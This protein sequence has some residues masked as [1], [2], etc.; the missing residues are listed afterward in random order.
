MVDYQ[1]K[2]RLL[3]RLREERVKTMR[4]SSLPLFTDPSPESRRHFRIPICISPVEMVQFSLLM[5]LIDR[6]GALKLLLLRNVCQ[7]RRGVTMQALKGTHDIL[8]DEV[9]KWDYMEGVIRVTCRATGTKRSVPR[10]LK[11]QELFQRGIGDTTDVVARGNVYLHGQRKSLCHPAPGKY[12]LSS[13]VPG[14]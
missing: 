2:F 12:S 5:S 11:R 8:P 10:S 6:G 3:Q 13:C 4:R 1:L 7:I 14:T 9:Y